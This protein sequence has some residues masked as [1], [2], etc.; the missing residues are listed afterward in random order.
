MDREIVWLNEGFV[1]DDSG[2][3]ITTTYIDLRE[4]GKR[5]A[6]PALVKGCRREYALEDGETILISK[7]ARF[8]EY[9][10]E[11]ILDKQEG[12]A[13]EETVTVTEETAAQATRQRAIIDMNEARELSNSRVRMVQRESY[14]SSDTK[15]KSLTFAKEWWIFSTSIDPSD[16]ERVTWKATLPE[17]Y[18]HISEIGQPAKFAQALAHMV[19]EQIGPQGKDGSMRDTTEGAEGP[20]TKHK[21]QWVMHGPVVYTDQVYDA[22]TRDFDERTRVAAFIFTKSTKYAAQREYR[23]AVLNQGAGEETV[24][25]R[26]SGMMRDALKRTEGGLIRNTPAPAER[27]EGDELGSTS[28]TNGTLTP[29]YGRKTKTERLTEWEESRW[30]TRTADGQVMT[31]EGERREHVKEKIVTEELRP[32]DDFQGALQLSRD[33]DVTT[34][35]QTAEEPLRNPGK[36]LLESSEEQ[37][38]QELALEENEWNDD[39]PGDSFTI[40]VIHRGTGRAYKSFEEAFADPAFPMSP[41]KE[42]WQERACSPE[43]I[44]KAYGAI[45]AL[46]WKMAYIKEEFRQ[47]VA[48]AGWYAMQCIRNIY[49]RLGDIV[50]SVWIERE[51]FVVIRLKESEGSNATGRIVIGPSGAYAYCLQLSD[52]EHSGHGGMEWGP[53]FFPIGD[54]VETFESYGWPAKSN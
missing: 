37:A 31:S 11:F 48:S 39:R 4:E 44:T 33:D 14:S 15:N 3:L 2:T 29:I 1:L 12:L 52:K 10:E 7:P 8:R 51:R 21:L 17:E 34:Q 32:D 9:G 22:L 5:A 13:K 30:E 35:G 45:D 54:Q 42:T 36:Q 41:T 26:I 53:M 47:D 43:E 6:I 28:R 40:P 18:D 50:D 25:L 27:P 49:A 24:L 23:F 38:V 46:N 20:L 19:A 16:E